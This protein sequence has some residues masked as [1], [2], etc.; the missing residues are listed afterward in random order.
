MAKG[1]LRQLLRICRRACDELAPIV[2][3]IYM[4][5]VSSDE[6]TKKADKSHFTMADGL[7]Q[8]LLQDH[9]LR[10]HVGDVVGEEDDTSVNIMTTPYTV[11]DLQVPSIL[12][13]SLDT[14]VEKMKETHNPLSLPG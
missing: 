5:Q 13:G 2:R 9:L 7:V 3:L 10:K 8:H 1:E 12:W 14:L 6:S 4:R 11:G